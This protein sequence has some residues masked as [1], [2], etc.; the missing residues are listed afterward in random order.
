MPDTSDSIHT[1]RVGAGIVVYLADPKALLN[2]VATLQPTVQY[3]YMFLNSVIDQNLQNMLIR[4][5]NG[6]VH[7]LNDG[8][9]LGLGVAY[10]RIIERAKCDQLDSVILFDQDSCPTESLIAELLLARSKLY[11]RKARPAVVGPQPI[12]EHNLEYKN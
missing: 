12:K 7:F 6:K 8:F 1:S 4:E 3:I 5:S 11:T 2:L 10:N 9:N